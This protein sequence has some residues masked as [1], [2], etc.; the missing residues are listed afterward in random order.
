[1]V[2]PVSMAMSPS[3]ALR[4]SPNP[5]ALTA[6]TFKRASQFVDHQQ[7]QSFR[8]HVLGDDQQRATALSDFSRIGTRS[9]MLLIFFS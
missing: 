5:G 2:P 3:I 7:G 8:F 1:M 9:R 6:A 4:R